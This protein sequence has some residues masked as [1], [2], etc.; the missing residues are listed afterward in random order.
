MK[1]LNIQSKVRR[2]F[3]TTTDSVHKDPVCYNLLNR[4]FKLVGPSLRLVSDIT[5][6]HTLEGFLYLITIFFDRKAVGWSFSEGMSAEET[7]IA[8]LNMAIKK[9]K[10]AMDMIF[11]SDRVVIC[12]SQNLPYNR[13]S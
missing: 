1:Q 7:V 3:K 11:H 12:L 5:Y 13:L 4:E 10:P 2:R 8:A 6:I 9:R